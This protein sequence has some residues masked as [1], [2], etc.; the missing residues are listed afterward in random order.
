MTALYTLLAKSNFKF[1]LSKLMVVPT[2]CQ[3]SL[4]LIRLSECYNREQPT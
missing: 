1:E 3:N 4:V 2:G